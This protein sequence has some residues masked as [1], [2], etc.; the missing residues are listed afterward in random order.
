[1]DIYLR[2][3]QMIVAGSFA[4][5][6]GIIFIVR[7]AETETTLF[8]LV[9]LGLIL[10]TAVLIARQSRKVHVLHEDDSVAENDFS[11]TTIPAPERIGFISRTHDWSEPRPLNLD[12]MQQQLQSLLQDVRRQ[13]ELIQ[14]PL[15]RQ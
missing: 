10:F 4:A 15:K 11:D 5:V 12:G 9:A 1:M 3:F 7:P 8:L 2:W 6:A 14:R 13:R